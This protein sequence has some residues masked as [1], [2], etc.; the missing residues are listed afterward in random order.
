MDDQIWRRAFDLTVLLP[1]PPFHCDPVSLSTALG[2]TGSR[3]CLS[4]RV[5]QAIISCSQGERDPFSVN[6]FEGSHVAALSI[7]S[8]HVCADI[9][10][11]VWPS[12]FWLR[13]FSRHVFVSNIY[14]MLS[15]TWIFKGGVSFDVFHFFKWLPSGRNHRNHRYYT[16]K[17]QARS[18]ELCRVVCWSSE[19]PKTGI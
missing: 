1:P 11:S 12:V 9:Q 7:K 16:K 8:A 14:F 2:C 17:M 3:V 19:L 10:A 4:F 5:C 6:T 15:G 18:I 13:R